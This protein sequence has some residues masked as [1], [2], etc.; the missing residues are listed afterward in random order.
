MTRPRLEKKISQKFCPFFLEKKT[1]P[2][3]DYSH[4]GWEKKRCRALVWSKFSPFFFGRNE[5]LFEFSRYP[6]SKNLRVFET[7]CGRWK[8][9]VWPNRAGPQI[10]GLWNYQKTHTTR[11]N[12]IFFKNQIVAKKPRVLEVRITGKHQTFLAD[13]WAMRKR[14]IPTFEVRKDF[15][16]REKKNVSQ[17]FPPLHYSHPPKKGT[18]GVGIWKRTGLYHPAPRITPTPGG[19]FSR[20][21]I[22]RW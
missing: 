1:I 3:L 10:E 11:P 22:F 20:M 16:G 14:A 9:W 7:W 12:P 6:C 2:H 17:L 19:W 18:P 13:G 21:G 8:N 5:K 15:G 4:R